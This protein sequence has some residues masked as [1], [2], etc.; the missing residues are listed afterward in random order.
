M[1]EEFTRWTDADGDGFGDPGTPRT[2][3]EGNANEVDNDIDCD[4][5]NGYTNPAVEETC[6]D[7]LDNDCDGVVDCVGA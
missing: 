1:D 6:E 2:A 7:S 3:C 4:D 5:T